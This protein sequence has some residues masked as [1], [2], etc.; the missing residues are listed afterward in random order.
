TVVA[1]GRRYVWATPLG[2]P[3][4]LSLLAG[5]GYLGRPWLAALLPAVAW[6]RL[7]TLPGRSAVRRRLRLLLPLLGLLLASALT[8]AYSHPSAEAA[9]FLATLCAC[10]ALSVILG[11]GRQGE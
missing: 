6:L 7:G 8:S 3:A 2:H 4:L 11:V 1:A 5:L 9:S 10:C